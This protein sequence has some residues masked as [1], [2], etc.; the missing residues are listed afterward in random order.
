MTMNTYTGWKATSSAPFLF[1][2]GLLPPPAAG[3]PMIRLE[4]DLA[5]Q[6]QTVLEALRRVNKVELRLFQQGRRLV[7]RIYDP[8]TKQ[9]RLEPV[10]DPVL[11]S[12]EITELLRFEKNGRPCEA[13]PKS[14]ATHLS[15]MEVEQWNLPMLHAIK[16]VPFFDHKGGLIQTN[17]YHA[18]LGIWLDLGDLTLSDV[19]NHPTPAQMDEAQALV[20][21]MLVDF[22]FSNVASRANALAM[23]LLRSVRY[24]INGPVPLFLNSASMPGSGKTALAQLVGVLYDGEVPAVMPEP[25]RDDEE[26]TKR[27]IGVLQAGQE[28]AIF[29]NVNRKIE[30]SVLASLATST[31]FSGRGLYKQEPVHLPNRTQWMFTANNPVISKEFERRFLLVRLDAGVED[32]QNRTFQHP[33]LHQ[34]AAAHR[35]ELLWAFLI[36]VKSWQVVGGKAGAVLEGGM[37][38][39][40]EV[41]GGITEFLD[42][43]PVF[44]NRQELTEQAGGDDQELREALHSWYVKF[45]TRRVKATELGELWQKAGH[46]PAG[47]N[48]HTH[49]HVGRFIATLRGVVVGGYRVDIEKSGRNTWYRLTLV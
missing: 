41:L 5:V 33:D 12:R 11:L 22:P 31:T 32:P 37:R 34:W 21:E 39:F 7:R 43:G 2:P 14:L 1:A 45:S 30:S 49:A 20:K 19:P 13:L 35:S 26:L 46:Q 8:R 25:P 15:N 40:C 38:R 42:Y 17:G 44:A 4:G 24:M 3:R 18:E 27:I 9:H 10:G 28:L 23:L 48:G 36:L 47:L 16:R 29:D 6:A